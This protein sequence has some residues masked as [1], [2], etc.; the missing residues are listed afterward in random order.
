MECVNTLL[1]KRQEFV[2]LLKENELIV[3]YISA[4]IAW[5]S[6]FVFFIKWVH[7]RDELA[8]IKKVIF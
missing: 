8:A 4:T 6:F 1:Q 2:T 5:I 7:V 3:V